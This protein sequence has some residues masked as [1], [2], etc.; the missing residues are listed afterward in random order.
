MLRLSRFCLQ[1]EAIKCSQNSVLGED[2]LNNREIKS[3][4]Q[5]TLRATWGIRKLTIIMEQQRVCDF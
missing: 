3:R 2:E 5:S 4:G 1:M